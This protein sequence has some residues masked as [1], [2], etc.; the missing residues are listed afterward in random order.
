MVDQD[1]DGPKRA[2]ADR[3]RREAQQTRPAFSE[4]LHA[5]IRDAVAQTEMAEPP[6]P[7]TARRLGPIRIATAVAA[8]LLIGTLAFVWYANF[9]SG[10]SPKPGEMARAGGPEHG[11]QEKIIVEPPPGPDEGLPS[12]TEVPGNPAADIGL[13]VD[14]TLTR[15][16]WAYLDHDAQLAARLLLDQ[17]PPSLAWPEDEL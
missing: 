16:R 12:P 11:G 4:S 14:A 8:T 5:R 13:L 1:T 9:R 6:R 3:L 15:R 7:A 17:L 2:L 10:T